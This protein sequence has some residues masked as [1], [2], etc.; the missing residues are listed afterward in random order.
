[1]II[2][3]HALRIVFAELS[4]VKIPGDK[5]IPSFAMLLA[6]SPLAYVFVALWR[7]KDPVALQYWEVL[8]AKQVQNKNGI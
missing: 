8:K 5:Q 4:V 3:P 1:M 2:H 7:Q 6:A